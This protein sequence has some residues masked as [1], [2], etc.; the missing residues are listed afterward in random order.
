VKVAFYAPMKAPDSP[1]PSGDR[2]LGR[3]FLEALRQAGFD[4]ALASRLQ[5]WNRTGDAELTREQERQSRGEAERLL[6]LWDEKGAAEPPC[7][8]FTYHCYWKAPDFLGPLVAGRLGIPYVIAEAIRAPRRANGPW[9]A[10]HLAAESAID[11]ASLVLALTRRDLVALEAREVP[12]QRLE[13]FPPFTD[14]VAPRIPRLSTNGRTPR[15][16]CV[17][18]MRSDAKRQGYRMLAEALTRLSH[19]DWTLDVI[20]DGDAREDIE[21]WFE[22]LGSRVRFLGQ[23][24]QRSTLVEHLASADLFVWPAEREAFG[25]VYLEAQACGCPVV[26]THVDGVPEVVLQGETGL[27][28]PPRD[29]AAFAA[30]VAEVLD[31]PQRAADLSAAASAWVARSRSIGAAATRLREHLHPIVVREVA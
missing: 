31:S 20:G 1:R 8:W 22:P 7:L 24:E 29:P 19:R 10:G 30:A 4:P 17:A 14:L 13:L 23:V 5:T 12:G 18:M 6:R 9:A 28:T 21:A 25:M 2:T 27:L 3:L 11:Q 26:G 16:L 15:L